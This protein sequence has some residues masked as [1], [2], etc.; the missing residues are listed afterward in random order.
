MI[1]IRDGAHSDRERHSDAQTLLTH[2]ERGELELGAP[3]HGWLAD[4]CGQFG[5]EFADRVRGLLAWPGVVEP[6]QVARLLN[7]MFLV[8]N[9]VLDLTSMIQEAWRTSPGIGTAG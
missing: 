3:S 5:G 6:P 9:L 7:V 1:V 8:E 2:A 4:V